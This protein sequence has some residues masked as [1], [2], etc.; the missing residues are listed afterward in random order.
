MCE[1]VSVTRLAAIYPMKSR[2]LFMHGIFKMHNIIH[3][4]NFV[5]NTLFKTSG[6]IC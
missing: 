4:V 1:C 5:E 2:R 6:D 3:Y